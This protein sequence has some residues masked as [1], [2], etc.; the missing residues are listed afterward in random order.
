MCVC[1]CVR[2]HACESAVPSFQTFQ[3]PSSN[4]RLYLPFLFAFTTR[5]ADVD[6]ARSLCRITGG[7]LPPVGLLE[8]VRSYLSVVM[9]TFS[10]HTP[11][12]VFLSSCSSSSCLTSSNMPVTPATPQHVMCASLGK[13]TSAIGQRV[14]VVP[15]GV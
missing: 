3:C 14:N 1:A 11:L 2:P 6:T 5:T 9:A 13:K 15:Q 7:S 4:A 12:P 10:S 8:C